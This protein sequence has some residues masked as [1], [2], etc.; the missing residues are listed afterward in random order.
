MG[1]IRAASTLFSVHKHDIY[2][3]GTKYLLYFYTNN[4][5]VTFRVLWHLCTRRNIVFYCSRQDEVM[6]TWKVVII[7]KYN[8]CVYIW[9]TS[10]FNTNFHTNTDDAVL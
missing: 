1:H 2:Y 8:L 3:D 10:S 6:V 9:L 5:A 4:F 7:I